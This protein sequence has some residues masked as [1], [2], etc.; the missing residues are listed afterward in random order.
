MFGLRRQ[1]LERLL[2]EPGAKTISANCSASA[3]A[4]RASTGRLRQTTPPK[5]LSGSQA[6]ARS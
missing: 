5:A 1:D 2:G 3:S 6:K 4:S